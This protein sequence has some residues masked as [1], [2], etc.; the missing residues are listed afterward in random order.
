[1]MMNEKKILNLVEKGE[2]ETL[3]FKRNFNKEGV[4]PPAYYCIGSGNSHREEKVCQKS[5]GWAAG[6][7]GYG[8]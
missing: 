8:K 5:N 4:A 3:E 1:M 7:M 2:S 6:K